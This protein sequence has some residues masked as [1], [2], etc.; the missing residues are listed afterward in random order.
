MNH[1]NPTLPAGLASILAFS[2]LGDLPLRWIPPAEVPPPFQQLLVHHHDMTS[3]LAGFHGNPISLIVIRSKQT[4]AS[5][6]R[7]VTL[8]AAGR[9]VEYG[10]IE[11][12]LESFPVEL[13]ARILA[14]DAPLGAILNASGLAYRSAPQGFFSVPGK[15]LSSIFQQSGGTVLYGRYN[16]LLCGES[17]CL[18]R[19]LEILPPADPQ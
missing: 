14:G 13:R 16:H 12:L 17:T 10:L 19:I 8:H 2:G 11:I 4:L 7:E 3:E 1:P 5:H 6:T 15:A 9:V 18:A